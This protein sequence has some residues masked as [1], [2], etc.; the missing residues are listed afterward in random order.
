[1]DHNSRKGIAYRKISSIVP[2]TMNQKMEAKI[3]TTCRKNNTRFKDPSFEP[4]SRSLIGDPPVP[5]SGMDPSQFKWA[6]AEIVFG[7]DGYSVFN[8]V[9]PNDIRQGKLGDCY[10]LCALSSLAERPSLITRLF[11]TEEPNEYGVYAV[12]LNI[13]GLWREVVVDDLFPVFENKQQKT[14]EFAF[15]RT[16]EDEL[17]PMI[18]EKAYA[19]VYGSYA[20]IEAGVA[21][22]ALRDLTGAPYK[23]YHFTRQFSPQEMN[24]MWKELVD[25][26]RRG[27]ICVCGTATTNS[28]GREKRLLNGLYAGH[29]YSLLDA[30]EVNDSRGQRCRIVLIRNP[31]GQAEWTGDWSD[32]SEKWTPQ[33]RQQFGVKIEDDGL[34]WMSWGDFV[35]NFSDLGFCKVEQNFLY[36]ATQVEQEYDL[37]KSI[38]RFDVATP[39]RYTISVDQKER[40]FFPEQSGGWLSSGTKYSYSYCRVTIAQLTQ[41]GIRYVDCKKSSEKNIF[42]T[43]NLQAGQ[44]VVLV[45]FYWDSRLTPEF[46]VSSYGVGPVGFKKVAYNLSLFQKTEY[47][48]WKDF[49]NSSYAS[50]EKDYEFDL[51]EGVFENSVKI[52]RSEF[53]SKRFGVWLNRFQNLDDSLCAEISIKATKKEGV[54]MVAEF[55]SGE[56]L[57]LKV[58][59]GSY[60]VLVVKYDPRGK[61]SC[62][63]SVVDYQL[64]ENDIPDDYSVLVR[65]ASIKVANPGIDA[66]GGGS[67]GGFM[68]GAQQ[69]SGPFPGED[70]GTQATCWDP[71]ERH[72]EVCV[73]I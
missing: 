39:G 62:N 21:L 47:F 40:R 50:F 70:G 1:M 24:Q 6:S 14:V 59:P 66:R 19:K 65:L 60:E 57:S 8:D 46:T 42:C 51:S 23:A 3:I 44:Y 5:D 29:A 28:S 27:W 13:N 2:R 48:I 64:H 32:K 30:Q 25:A 69:R 73:L 31:H 45:E 71:D 38:L 20:N 61:S 53:E 34:F 72:E 26:E 37:N 33:L 10:F 11:D 67:M 18:L 68:P 7:K 54:G 55:T 9:D 16:S 49:C 52:R 12:W 22:Y 63:Y 17:W 43:E 58:S 15:S 4:N 36:N 56:D 41:G 35:E